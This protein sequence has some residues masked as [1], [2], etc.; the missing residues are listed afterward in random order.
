MTSAG[1][2]APVSGI[3]AGRGPVFRSARGVLILLL[4]VIYAGCFEFFIRVSPALLYGTYV[5]IIGCVSVCLIFDWAVSRNIR[6]VS[7][8]L[9][10]LLFYFVWA[11]IAISSEITAVSEGM[12]MYVKNILIICSLAFAVDRET[13]RPFAR[14]LQI[15]VLGNFALALYEVANPEMIAEIAQTREAGG[16]AFD[17]LRPAGLWSNP[18]EASTAFIFS[19]FMSRWAGGKLAWLGRFA[20]VGGVFLSASRTGALLLV[21]CGTISLIYWL[22]RHRIDSGRLTFICGVLM[23]AGAMVFLAVNVFGLN[24]EESWQVARMLDV[25]ESKH[26][27]GEASRFYI[28]KHATEVALSGPPYGFGLFTFQY[29]AQPLIPT[30]VDPP[31]HNIYIV[32]WGEAGPFV[33]ATFLLL[34]AEGFR[35]I[36]RTSMLAA[37]RLPLLLMWLCYFAIGFTWHNQFTAFSGMI[38]AALLWHLPTV[39]P[40]GDVPEESKAAELV[41]A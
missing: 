1:Y 27:A 11:M 24:P 26:G 41:L 20:S 30:I 2:I 4:V 33:W 39:M 8:Y 18:D 29:H 22:R 36:F 6:S 13:L 32:I 10:W 38:Y 3:E 23:V 25:S 14:M 7:L 19:L 16:T 21:F 9:V 31:A 5:V 35:R 34:L 40:S 17:V 28:A 12:R 37:D 15:V